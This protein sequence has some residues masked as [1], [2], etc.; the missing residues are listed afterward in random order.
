M[1]E[2][3]DQYFWACSFAELNLAEVDPA[4]RMRPEDIAS[5]AYPPGRRE[6]YTESGWKKAK[7]IGLA[8]YE[9]SDLRPQGLNSS[10]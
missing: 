2:T 3:K 9:L 7:E 4:L 10:Y 6:R 1:T 8:P 5:Y